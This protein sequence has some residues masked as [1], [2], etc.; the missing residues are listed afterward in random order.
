MPPTIAAGAEQDEAAQDHGRAEA[1]VEPAGQHHE[2]RRRPTAM[3]A[4]AVATVAEQGAFQPAHR[5]RAAR[6]SRRGQP[7]ALRLGGDAAGEAQAHAEA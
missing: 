6:S 4:T 5:P 3:T 1:P 2:A 7:D